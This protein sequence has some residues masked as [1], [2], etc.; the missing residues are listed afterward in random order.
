MKKKKLDIAKKTLQIEI[1]SL[2]KLKNNFP[3][4]FNKAVET[5]V[6]CKKALTASGTITLELALLNIPMIIMYRLSF[7][8]YLIMSKA[9]NIYQNCIKNAS[10]NH[11]LRRPFLQ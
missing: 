10:G 6:N 11:V 7:I 2:K 3:K 1:D 5:I 4:N 9:L 8:T